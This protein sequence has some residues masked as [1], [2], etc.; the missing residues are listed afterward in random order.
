MSAPCES[1]S[2]GINVKCHTLLGVRASSAVDHAPKPFPGRLP[3]VRRARRQ[4]LGPP[5][6]ATL[7]VEIIKNWVDP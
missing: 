6:P 2:G 3:I 1:R 5:V 4:D 7:A